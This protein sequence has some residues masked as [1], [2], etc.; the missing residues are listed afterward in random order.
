MLTYPRRVGVT[1]ERAQ[2]L[3]P[4]AHEGSDRDTELTD[5]LHERGARQMRHVIHAPHAAVTAG[6][7][8]RLIQRVRLQQT[9]N[10]HTLLHS[11]AVTI[12]LPNF[13]MYVVGFYVWDHNRGTRHS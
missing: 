10:I 2:R 3:R 4:R 8:R 1:V 11:Y 13:L 12:F 5:V 9:N 6:G 7:R